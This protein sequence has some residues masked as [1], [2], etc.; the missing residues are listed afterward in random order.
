MLNIVNNA[1]L[2]KD[3]IKLFSKRAFCRNASGCIVT[4]NLKFRT[5]SFQRI[6]NFIIR[7]REKVFRIFHRTNSP[8]LVWFDFWSMLIWTIVWIVKLK[9]H[10]RLSLLINVLY[11]IYMSYGL[12][13]C[14]ENVLFKETDIALHIIQYTYNIIKKNVVYCVLI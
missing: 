9:I 8:N 6:I 14:M 4:K 11:I 2:K 10:L 1:F 5:L 12:K 13:K 7:M 3:K